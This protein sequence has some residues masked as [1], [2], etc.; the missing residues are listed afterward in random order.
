ML[1]WTIWGR[2]SRIREVSLRRYGSK[3]VH[4]VTVYIIYSMAYL[5]LMCIQVYMYCVVYLHWHSLEFLQ[6]NIGEEPEVMM[7]VFVYLSIRW[8][9]LI[10]FTL[11]HDR[12]CYES[13]I[14]HFT[15]HYY[16]ER[17]TVQYDGVVSVQFRRADW[18]TP[19]V[20]GSA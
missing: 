12:T 11:S 4:H 8:L 14:D 1:H 20:W 5:Q 10:L 9:C 17:H 13:T 16:S 3:R 7:Q 18:H 15:V 6:G 2:E 19:C